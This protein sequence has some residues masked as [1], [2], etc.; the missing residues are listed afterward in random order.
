MGIHLV[1]AV[2][3]KVETRSVPAAETRMETHPVPAVETRMETRLVPIT[4]R[5][6]TETV[7]PAM[8]GHLGQELMDLAAIIQIKI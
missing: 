4:A 6:A 3:I 2:G 8:A 7:L 1:P 5:I